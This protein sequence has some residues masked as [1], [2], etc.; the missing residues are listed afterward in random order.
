MLDH[1]PPVALQIVIPPF[2]PELKLAEKVILAM[3]SVLQQDPSAHTITK[4]EIAVTAWRLYPDTFCLKGSPNLPDT[5]KVYVQLAAGKILRNLKRIRLVGASQ[6]KLTRAGIETVQRLRNRIAAEAERAAITAIED[7]KR[8]I[9]SQSE[10]D[11]LKTLF[12]NPTMRKWAGGAYVGPEDA[13]VF[14]GIRPKSLAYWP[15]VHVDELLKKA[16]QS[17]NVRRLELSYVML[18]IALALHAHLM[19]QFPHICV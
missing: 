13:R 10:I 18:D 19:Q 15:F 16:K 6:F 2:V 1:S 9:L 5:N 4:E 7:A 11:E 12:V 3:A 8:P 17:R 14:W